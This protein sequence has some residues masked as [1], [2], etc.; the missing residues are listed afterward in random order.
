MCTSPITIYR[1]YKVGSSKEYLVPCG[2]C[3]ECRAAYQSEFSLACLLQAEKSKTLHFFTLTYNDESLPLAISEPDIHGNLIVG[4][5]RGFPKSLINQ[6]VDFSKY[7]R[8]YGNDIGYNVC[9]S[10]FRKDVQDWLKRFRQ[11]CRREHIDI[12]LSM[13]CFGE[14][15]ESRHRPH[16]HVLVCGLSDSQARMLS[17][18]WIFGY[19][20]LKPIPRFNPDG[21]DAFSLT[22]KYVSKYICKRNK[23]PWF[24]QEGFAESPRKQTSIGFGKH[25]DLDKLRPFYLADDCARLAPEVRYQQIINRKKSISYHGQN[26]RLPRYA[27]DYFYKFNDS[28]FCWPRDG[29]RRSLRRAKIKAVRGTDFYRLPFISFNRPEFRS[30]FCPPSVSRSIPLYRWA[31]AYERSKHNE[32]TLR[33]LREGQTKNLFKTYREAA[34]FVSSV[35][36][37]SAFERETSKQR[38]YEDSLRLVKDGQ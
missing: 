4:F 6:N 15:G 16:Y 38:K 20:C 7:C 3:A 5:E 21:S 9:P 24:V 36:Y 23:L 18:M 14:Y 34:N 11:K 13:A 37:V 30:S 10:L 32:S 8:P 33:Q 22:S 31:L 1:Q 19:S 28:S 27:H 26:Y 2:K 35:D 29:F 25:L 12:N 17:R